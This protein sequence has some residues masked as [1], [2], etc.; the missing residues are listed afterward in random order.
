MSKTD[1][2]RPPH[3]LWNA[4]A[5][6]VDY[7]SFG[8]AFAFVSLS[9]VMPAFIRLLTEAAPLVGLAT[10][11]FNAGWTL[12][13]LAMARLVRD[14][15][16][17]KPYVLAGLAGRVSPFI[18]A[19]AL[20]AGLAERPAAMLAVLF[21]GL[22]VFAVSDGVASLPWYDILA[23]AI[24][25]N[26][27]G[28]VIG[29]AQAM[30][31]LGGTA[32]GGLVSLILARLPFPHSYAL[33]FAL[34]GL[35]LIPSTVALILL[36]EPPPADSPERAAREPGRPWLR[37]LLADRTFLLLMACRIVT[38][39]AGLATPFYVIHARAV[40]GLPES[41]IG[42]FIIAQTLTGVV[43]SLVL[44]VI[45]ER[46]GPHTVIRIGGVA[47]VAGPLFALAAHLS[48]GILGP[49][50]PFVFV[51]VG[52]AYNTAVLGFSNYTLEIAPP[53]LCTAYIGTA[54]TM[55]G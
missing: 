38:S 4:T 7:G 23:R 22:G 16:R 24:P 43:G 10:T 2:A 20:W 53:E 11:I 12:P 26:R 44:G 52:L 8:V 21:V 25:V 47:A 42:T 17:K 19:L 40:L 37:P 50:Y 18:I 14:R 1:N 28:R 9:S 55:T 46:W 13:Q 51:T 29:A 15:P 45:S 32:V 5:F 33:L 39:M 41:V 36:R 49:A 6:I 31:G 3:F 34:W 35:V 27:R 30:I 48:G 54:N